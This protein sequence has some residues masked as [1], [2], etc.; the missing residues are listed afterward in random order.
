MPFYQQEGKA[1]A[2]PLVGEI[3]YNQAEGKIKTWDGSKWITISDYGY[4]TSNY[5]DTREELLRKKHPGLAELWEELKEAQ[6]KYDAYLALCDVP[7]KG[8]K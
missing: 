1:M 2:N 5:E 4:G 3:Y 6:E 7:K 8:K